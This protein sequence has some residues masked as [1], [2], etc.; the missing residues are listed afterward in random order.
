MNNLETICIF[1]WS[2]FYET[3][4]WKRRDESCVRIDLTALAVNEYHC[5]NKFKFKKEDQFYN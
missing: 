1:I 5:Y 3:N 4:T 2:L